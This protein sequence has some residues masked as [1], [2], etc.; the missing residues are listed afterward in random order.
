ML[1]ALLLAAATLPAETG[2]APIH[3]WFEPE[4][5]DGVQ[6][7]FSYWTGKTKATGSWGIA[8]PGISSEWSQGGESEWNSIG[9][10]ADETNASC[11]RAFIVPRA[12]KVH[13]WVRYVDHRRQTEPFRVVLHQ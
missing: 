3:L 10:G 13:V 12:G 11:R 4:W 6:G 5:F 7:H 1:L 2:R 9:A 8:G